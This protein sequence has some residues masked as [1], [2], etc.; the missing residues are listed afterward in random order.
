MPSSFEPFKTFTAL[1]I[2]VASPEVMKDWSYGEV[3]K[4]E[5]INYRTFKSEKDGLFDER[6]FGPTKDY[7]CYCG[8]YKKAR[9]KGIICDKC[10]VEVT[11]KRVRR[12]R[13]GHITLASPVAHVWYFRGIPSII[14]VVLGVSPRDIEGVVYFSRYLITEF[15]RDK[16]K[17]ALEN[18]EKDYVK[19]ISEEADA[20]KKTALKDERSEGAEI[21]KSVKLLSILSERQYELTASYLRE[22]AEPMMGAEAVRRALAGVDLNKLSVSL[23]ERLEKSKGERRLWA[24]RRLRFIENLQ[25]AKID[26]TWLVLTI[27]PVTPPDIRPMVQLEGGRFATSDLNDLYR[28]VI[29]RNNRLKQLLELGAPEI[30]VRN[31][32]RMLQES[33]DA[34]IDSSKARRGKV[35]RGKRVLR[36]FADLLSGK[37]GRFRQNLLGKRVDYSG[38]SVIIVGPK[39][40]LDQVGLPREMAL[41]LFKP[42]VLREILLRGLASNLR[43]A[44]NY[45]DG[46]SDDVWDILEELVQGHPVLLNRA[47]SLHRLSVL[48]FYPVLVEG[49]AIQLHPSVCSGFNADFDGD[50]MAVHLPIS[51]PAIEEVKRLIL[52]TKNLL[53]PATGDPISFPSKGQVLGT[54]YLTSIPHE[55]QA[56]KAA[57]LKLFG[58]AEE[59]ILAH[60]LGKIGLREKI[61]VY[62]DGKPFE[63]SVGRVIFN[64]VLPDFLRFFNEQAGGK[65]VKSFVAQAIERE[66]EETVAK[67]IDDIKGLGFKYATTSGIS[68]AV[69]DGVVPAT[70]DKILS[71]SEK[72]AAEVEQNFRRGL[73]TDG[74]RREQ[75][76]LVWAEATS[77]LDD[78]SW[79]ELGEENPIKSMINSGAARATRDQVKQMTGMRGHIVDPTGKFIE[80]P[81]LSN[82]TEGLSSFEYFV[83][84]RGARKGLVDTALRTADAGYLTRRLVDVAQDVL[85]REKDCNT[86]SYVTIGREDETLIVSFGRRLLGRT[87]A[88]NIKVGSKMVVKKNEIFSQ[89]AADQIEGSS[90]AEAKVRSPLVCESQG[91]ICA[92]C[93]GVDLGHNLPVEIGSPVGLIAAQSIG[94]PGTQ[95]TLK[96]KHAGGIAV[97]TDITQGLPRV[98]EIFEARTPKYEGILAR[99]D[100]KISVVEEGEKRK[101]FLVGKEGT[102]EFDVPFGREILVK[103][104]DK[105]K[106]GTQ[107]LAGSL[108]PKKMVEIVGL[109]ATQKYLVNEA[110]KVYS[111]QGI[112][113]DDIHLEVVVRQMFNKL[114]V[115]E[116]GDTSLIP[117]EV[118]TETQL[119]ESNDL[120]KKGQ[121]KVKVEHTLLGITKSSLKTESWMAAASFM[122]T[123]RVLTEAAIAGKVDKLT[124]LKENVII[125]RLI[126]TGERSKINIR[127]KEEAV[128]KEK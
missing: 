2:E 115:V 29:N 43:S 95:L 73:L 99:Q 23:R 96:T 31:E 93:Y 19:R 119:K 84:G 5:T 14:S 49:S 92:T 116:A 11:S 108:D 33:V 40:K 22:F 45:L 3:T 87:A 57:D 64:Q 113:L 39:L 59:A 128:K 41:E 111:S 76:R 63:T 10:G 62:L 34:L 32:K 118:I 78:L 122:E 80:L 37:Q 71:Q 89:E 79:N 68:L 107:L 53:R 77:Q 125:G 48:G 21:L 55:E 56:R 110:L 60:S 103:D 26:P 44:K 102:E 25:K 83:G 52:S 28:T 72:K 81:I 16:R 50:T 7:E 15:D 121:K 17:T 97:S 8:K 65:Q 67:L 124:G 101:M 36:S 54:Y 35:Q 27:L 66:S 58:N 24:R 98:E 42:H 46:R 88:E 61:S 94:E 120:L 123:T 1:K 112:S 6:I 100:G 20:G 9:F 114:K 109:A 51:K 12:E 90:L 30:I 127:K 18:F 126:P 75:T 69:T 47:P 4:P 104:G 91:G 105:V 117:G 86:E 38:R 74:E 106:M 70:K 85:I 82:Y 13:M